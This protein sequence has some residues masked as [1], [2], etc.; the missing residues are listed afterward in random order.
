MQNYLWEDQLQEDELQQWETLV[1]RVRK[2]KA[3]HHASLLS[4]SFHLHSAASIIST[5]PSTS[6]VQY[7]IHHISVQFNLLRAEN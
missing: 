2:T 1:R 6:F 5:V 4:L 3:S 7:N